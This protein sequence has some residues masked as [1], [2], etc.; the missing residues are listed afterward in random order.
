LRQN[1]AKEQLFILNSA[2][3]IRSLLISWSHEIIFKLL[4]TKAT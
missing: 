2:L 1:L 4:Q 3:P